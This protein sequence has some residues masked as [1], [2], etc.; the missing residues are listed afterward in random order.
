MPNC[1]PNN[2]NNNKKIADH[3][4]TY[5]PMRDMATVRSA[6]HVLS[7]ACSGGAV[8]RSV[9]TPS[10]D[11]KPAIQKLLWWVWVEGLPRQ[12]QKWPWHSRRPLL[13]SW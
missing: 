10:R 9:T 8:L 2:N 4:T 7:R 12:A 5:E 6:G 3:G 1:A 13:M 11:G